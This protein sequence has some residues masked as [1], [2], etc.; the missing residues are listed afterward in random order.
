[1]HELLMKSVRMRIKSDF[2]AKVFILK[3]MGNELVYVEIAF[4]LQLINDIS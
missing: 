3:S 1:M 4:V 2:T